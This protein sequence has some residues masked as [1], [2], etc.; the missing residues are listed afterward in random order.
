M[1]QALYRCDNCGKLTEVERH[2][3]A[4]ARLIK[5]FAAIDNTAVNYIAG[6]ITALL[7]GLLFFV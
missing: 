6:F 7:G 3:G 1:L 5:G 2:C 4:G